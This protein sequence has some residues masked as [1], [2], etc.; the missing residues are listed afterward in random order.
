MKYLQSRK[1]EG[2]ERLL[3]SIWDPAMFE[4]MNSYLEEV[5]AQQYTTY[6][7]N[8]FS[9]Q[10]FYYT[11]FISKFSYFSPLRTKYDGNIL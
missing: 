10:Q 5:L 4:T 1:A 11:S 8:C 7:R 3:V 6:I 2:M 9:G